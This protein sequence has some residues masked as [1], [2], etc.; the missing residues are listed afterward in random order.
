MKSGMRIESSMNNPN[1]GEYGSP[2]IR[3]QTKGDISK[4]DALPMPINNG[5]TIIVSGKDSQGEKDCRD[6]GSS[7]AGNSKTESDDAGYQTTSPT[8]MQPMYPNA[9]ASVTHNAVSNSLPQARQLDPIFREPHGSPSWSNVVSSP[10]PLRAPSRSTSGETLL[11]SNMSNQ[12]GTHPASFQYLGSA[13]SRSHSFDAESPPRH[14]NIT[15]ASSFGSSSTDTTKTYPQSNSSS[16]M[17]PSHPGQSSF[18]DSTLPA[19]NQSSPMLYP[20]TL[21]QE[22]K[23]RPSMGS[24]SPISIGDSMCT[25]QTSP[26]SSPSLSPRVSPAMHPR[27]HPQH[28]DGP[29]PM[30]HLSDA[31]SHEFHP[32]HASR[33]HPHSLPQSIPEHRLQDPADNPAHPSHHHAPYTTFHHGNL[34]SAGPTSPSRHALQSSSAIG[35]HYHHHPMYPR[36]RSTGTKPYSTGPSS[37]HTPLHHRSSTEVLKTLLRK[38]A[39]LYEPETSFAVSLVTWLVGR[40]LALSQGYFT[41]Q[42]LQAGVHACVA[43][44]IEEGHVTRT[45]VNRCMQVILNSCFHYIIPRPDGSEECGEAFRSVFAREAADEEH[46]LGTLPPPWNDLNL[47]CMTDDSESHSTL[48]NEIDDDQ[49]PA[50]SSSGGLNAPSGRER[51]SSVGQA[52]DSSLDSTKRSVLLCFNE[53]IRSASDVFRCHNEFI[54]DVAHTG[55]LN[56]SHE[57]W[58]SFFSGQSKAYRKSGRG[59]TTAG[60][61]NSDF[62][63]SR[64]LHLADMHDR[65]DRQGL[66]KLRTCWCAKRYDHDHSFCAFA[67]VDVNRGW[68]RRDPF[69]YNYKPTM[70]PYVKPLQDAK[71]CFV[72][73]CPLGVKC[74]HAHSKEEI[75]YHPESYKRQ[76]CRNAP[77]ACPLGDICPNTHVDVPSSHPSHIGYNRQVKRHYHDH[78]STFH[79]ATHTGGPKKRVSGPTGHASGFGKL[80]DGSPMLY[81]DPAPLSEF[82]NT[83]LLPGLQAMFRDHSFSIFY[84]TTAAKGSPLEYGPFGYRNAPHQKMTQTPSSNKSI[85]ES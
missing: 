8:M 59:A 16:G 71:D 15:K 82:E 33:L 34:R 12:P 31:N 32:E 61:N 18:K 54:R 20:S 65:M 62:F 84:S 28:G 24:Y 11:T 57:D 67:H 48:F 46:L 58:Q 80:P 40:R 9:D 19:I 60:N 50:P 55:N 27:K 36:V 4:I 43:G 41:R 73:M 81:I 7:P 78:S 44:K 42:Q 39:C 75:I 3:M 30:W 74:N 13:R 68:L 76:P 14:Y 5:D 53:N 26:M 29:P 10:S 49:Q 52:G 23:P 45:K 35:A 25:D 6:V 85:G 79:R 51:S 47:L 83:L 63:Q 21:Y 1:R 64:Y 17:P 37:S 22:F 56:L 77:G 66:S 69:V 72:N 70:C 2:H 38:K